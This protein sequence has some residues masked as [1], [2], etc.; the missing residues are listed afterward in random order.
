MQFLWSSV[1]SCHLMT[2]TGVIQL[3]YEEG[4]VYRLQE[5]YHGSSTCPKSCILCHA[6]GEATD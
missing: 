4:Y 2:L 6:V 3:T 5:Q 1:V